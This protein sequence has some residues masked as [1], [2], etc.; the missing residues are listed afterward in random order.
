MSRLSEGFSRLATFLISRGVGDMFLI[1]E[2]A[3]QESSI[4]VLENAF[5]ELG[6]SECVFLICR[7]VRR[8]FFCK[9]V[10][11]PHFLYYWRKVSRKKRVR[12]HLYAMTSLFKTESAFGNT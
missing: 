4:K 12:R 6:P 5:F 1:N 2:W 11:Y 10:S 8:L 9:M 7:G 3:K